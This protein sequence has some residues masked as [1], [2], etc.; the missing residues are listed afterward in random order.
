MDI[1]VKNC[2]DDISAAQDN[3]DGKGTYVK[4]TE[5]SATYKSQN[6]TVVFQSHKPGDLFA[7][8]KTMVSYVFAASNGVEASCDFAVTVGRNFIWKKSHKIYWILNKFMLH[9]IIVAYGKP[10][11]EDGV[12]NNIIASYKTC[13]VDPWV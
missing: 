8:G 2:P 9:Y 12:T 5:P 4:W 1:V 10:W 13:E 11:Y 6:T 3:G 7:A